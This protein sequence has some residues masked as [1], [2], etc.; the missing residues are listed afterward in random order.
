M[1]PLITPFD[2]ASLA[3]SRVLAVWFWG[4]PGLHQLA[5]ALISLACLVI[6]LFLVLNYLRP[7]RRRE[8]PYHG[9][10]WLLAGFL[11]LCAASCFQNVFNSPS[12]PL[13]GVFSLIMAG[14]SCTALLGLA[15]QVCRTQAPCHPREFEKEMAERR[16]AEAELRQVN[17]R[18]SALLD[19]STEVSIIA[20]DSHGLITLFNSGAE[21]MLGYSAEELIGKS[22]PVLLHDAVEVR[23][24]AARLSAEFGTRIEGFSVFVERARREGHEVREWTYVRKDGSR[25]TVLLAVTAVFDSE[26]RINGFLG[27]AT[28]VTERLRVEQ[29]LRSS[30]SRFR[31]LVDAN[32]FGVVFGDMDGNISDANDAFLEMVGYTRQEMA[33]G[34]LP[35]DALVPPGWARS[36]L[37][38]RVELKRWGRCAPFEL[39][40]KRREGHR[41]PVLLGVALL[42]ENQ[43][44]KGGSPVVAFCL[45][46]TQQKHLEAQLRKHADEL[47]ETDVRKNEFLAMLGHELRNPLAPIRNAVK[48]MKQRGSD[49]PDTCWARDVIDQQI[50][51]MAQLV[52]DLLEISRVTRGKVRLQREVV[53]VATIVAYAVETSRPVIDAHGHRLSIALPARQIKVDADPVRMAQVLS[54]L[55]NN[56]AK[57]TADGG[58]IRLSIVEETDD[59]VFRVRDNGVGIPPDMLPRVFDLFAQA[60]RSLDRSQGGLGLG[61]TLVR[62]LVEMHGGTVKAASAGLDQGSEFQVRLPLWKLGNLERPG[63]RRP[64]AVA[65]RSPAVVARHAPQTRKVLV[66]DDNVTSAQTLERVLRLEGHEVHVVHDGPSVFEIIRRRQFDVVFMDIGLPGM[67]GYEVAQRLRHQP[68]LGNPLLVAVTGYAEDEAR[69]LSREAGFDH[70]LVK[71]VDPETILA[72][73]SSLEWSEE[74]DQT[75]MIG[76]QAAEWADCLPSRDGK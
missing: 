30:E 18:L 37:R 73:L 22:T 8:V 44:V 29:R 47:A 11:L 64:D 1:N 70:H 33:A 52:D 38:C 26:G 7:W 62:S 76:R 56:A 28:D 59:V 31:R 40:C 42:D 63:V 75:L 6:S 53:D 54:N 45:D 35:F 58:L 15:C 12:S 66:V 34:R 3:G 25:L 23:A 51:Q 68:E 69:R 20:T 36:L 5:D 61:L 9:I 24:H 39:E 32:I 60:D 2:A 27:V 57:Y 19:A 72:L 48:I 21:Q 43:P 67:T 71:P 16:K 4:N 46:L 13:T 41:L 49:D 55:L 17:A 50:R 74:S 10:V 14:L 65:N